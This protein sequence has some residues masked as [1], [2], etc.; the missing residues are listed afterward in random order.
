[1]SALE[2]RAE[3]AEQARYDAIDPNWTSS[4]V[5]LD[6]PQ[7]RDSFVLDLGLFD[8]ALVGIDCERELTRESEANFRLGVLLPTQECMI[9]FCPW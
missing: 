9:T 7:A 2:A 3:V 8:G 4:P 5:F 1:M 6:N